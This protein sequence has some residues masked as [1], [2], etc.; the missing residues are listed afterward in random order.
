MKALAIHPDSD[1]VNKLEIASPCSA[2]WDDMVGDERTR[3]CADCRKN[4]F[5]ITEMSAA[6]V[7]QLVFEAEGRVCVRLYRRTDGTVLTSDCPVGL[8]ERTWRKA[9]NGMLATAALALT[10]FSGA[11]L[12]FFGRTTCSIDNAQGWVQSQQEYPVAGGLEPIEMGEAM[13]EPVMG[14]VAMPA[15]PAVKMGKLKVV[16]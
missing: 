9:R 12:F 8:A 5:N 14:D 15:P 1:F 6:E 13:P 2:S 11:L 3:H 7:K 4:V 16:D 10:L